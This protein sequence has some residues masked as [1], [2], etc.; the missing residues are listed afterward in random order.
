M[1]W[2]R[3]IEGSNIEIE[4]VGLE[5]VLARFQA[6]QDT[7]KREVSDLRGYYL[8]SNREADLQFLELLHKKITKLEELAKEH[9]QR[10]WLAEAREKMK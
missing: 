4:G 6:V 8:A 3:R 9:D 5:L 2:D 7:L 10:M 1:A